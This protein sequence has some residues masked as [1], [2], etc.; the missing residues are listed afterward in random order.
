MAG[1]LGGLVFGVCGW[2]GG[3]LGFWICGWVGRL[4]SCLIDRLIGCLVGLVG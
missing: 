2:V 3:C 4:F 1:W